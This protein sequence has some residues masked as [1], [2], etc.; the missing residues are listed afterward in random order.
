M[1]IVFFDFVTHHG[2]AS[3]STIEF[4]RRLKDRVDVS[5]VDPY[6]CCPEYAAGVRE[7]ELDYHVLCPS[8]EPRVVGGQGRALHRA[9]RVLSSMPDL[10]TVRA[11]LQAL[12]HKLEPSVVCANNLKGAS[13]VACT[14]GLRRVPLVIYMREWY[15]PDRMPAYGRWLCRKRCSAL[16]ALSRSTKTALMCSRIDPRMIHVLHNSVDVDGVLA[17]A[18]HSLDEP[19]PRR[20]AAI[21]I[22]L[23]ASISRG[24]GQ[25]TAIKA[26]KRICAGGHDAVLWIAGEVA[27]AAHEAYSRET[28][29]LAVRIGVAERV[30]WLGSRRDIPQLMRA[31]TVV[32]LPSRAEGLGRVIQEAMSL[33]K[34]VAATPVGGIQDLIVPN[35]TGLFFEVDDDAGLAKCVDQFVRDP[36]AA[37][38]MGRQAQEYMRLSFSPAWQI[39]RA[40]DLFRSVTTARPDH[41]YSD[42]RP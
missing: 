17:Q 18:D 35:V 34:P 11:R 41:E 21:R 9:W 26:M 8:S 3:R 15:M 22:L 32:V 13:M 40:L 29:A 12:L 28:R 23:P 19:H 25:H 14:F 5:I 20:D 39:E 4:A 10:L 1:R 6:G 24:K 31:S 27:F 37:Q 33:A 42:T 36:R 16:F 30:Q 2:G 38:R 7:A